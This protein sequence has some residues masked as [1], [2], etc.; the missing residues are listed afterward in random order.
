MVSSVNT[1]NDERDEILETE[2]YFDIAN[3]PDIIFSADRIDLVDGENIIYG[4]L[5]IK[6]QQRDLS[7]PVSI[8]HKPGS[9]RLLLTAETR[10]RRKDYDLVFGSMNGLIGDKVDIYLTIVALKD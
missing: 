4:K 6:D 8:D 10:I 7:M 1:G 5:T 9:G 2:P 3:F